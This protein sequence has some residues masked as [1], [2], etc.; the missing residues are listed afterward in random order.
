MCYKKERSQSQN[1]IPITSSSLWETS[2]LDVVVP[3]KEGRQEVTITWAPS[4]GD[5]KKNA[6]IRG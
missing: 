1:R 3:R 2:K 5:R 4:I 6:Q